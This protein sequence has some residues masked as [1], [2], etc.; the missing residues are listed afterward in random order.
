MARNYGVPHPERLPL[1][2]AVRQEQRKETAYWRWLT[3]VIYLGSAGVVIGGICLA[4]LS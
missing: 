1:S 4:V 3:A 2:G